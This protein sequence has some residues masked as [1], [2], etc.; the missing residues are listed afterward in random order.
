MNMI[1]IA[2]LGLSAA[3]LGLF[4]KEAHA[5]FTHMISLAACLLI[6][7]YSVSR[8]SSVF[9]L[10]ETL[11][12]YLSEQKSYYKILLKIIGITY[13][14]DFS[15][16]LCRDAGFGAIAGQIEIFGKISILAVSAPIILAL[17]ETVYALW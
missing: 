14:A 6:L 10:L 2:C 12:G 7:F 4:L 5:P 11:A 16:N 9:E 17:M 3:M 1:K 15:S 8:L 13:V